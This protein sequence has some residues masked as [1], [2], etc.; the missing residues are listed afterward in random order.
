M[1]TK[2]PGSFSGVF[3]PINPRILMFGFTEVPK[4]R[5]RSTSRVY[6]FSVCPWVEGVGSVRIWVPKILT[7]VIVTWSGIVIVQLKI[8]I[9]WG[10]FSQISE[11]ISMKFISFLW[12]PYESHVLP[13]HHQCSPIFM[14]EFHMFHH[15]PPDSSG[16]NPKFPPKFPGHRIADG[17]PEKSAFLRMLLQ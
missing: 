15:F 13:L 7:D 4:N 1:S 8:F 5:G 17:H 16:L 10:G 11:A 3:T 6:Q 14:L 9:L 12:I 2:K